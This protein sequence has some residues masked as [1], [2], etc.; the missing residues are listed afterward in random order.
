VEIT[1]TISPIQSCNS[2]STPVC[3]MPL[4]LTEEQLSHRWKLYVVMSPERARCPDHTDRLRESVA[5]PAEPGPVSKARVSIISSG[6]NT[7][8]VNTLLIFRF[9][10]R[11]LVVLTDSSC[12]FSSSRKI[13]CRYPKQDRTVSFHI[14]CVP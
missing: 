8:I 6:V 11:C 3:L 2:A 5:M 9:L 4:S 12:F 7:S 13:F 1:V 10:A 14:L